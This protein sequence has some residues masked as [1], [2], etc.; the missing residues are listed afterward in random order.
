MK[1]Y[2]LIFLFFLIQISIILF[3][4]TP[5]V[6]ASSNFQKFSQNPIISGRGNGYWEGI[7]IVAPSV[8]KSSNQY[9]MWF[10]GN[11]GSGWRIGYATSNNGINNWSINASPLITVGTPDGWEKEVI[12]P[13]VI[14]D[15]SSNQYKMW[16]TSSNTDHWSVGSDRFRLRYATSNDGITWNIN[17]GWV[18]YGTA[19]AWDEGGI[20]RGISVVKVND[21]YNLWY[22]A[23]NTDD[24]GINPYWRIGYATSSDGIHWDKQNNHLPVIEPTEPWEGNNV[25]SP[26]VIYENGTYK[27]WYNSGVADSPNQIVYAYSA[28]GIHWIKPFDKNPSLSP[29]LGFD[30]V[31]VGTPSVL[32]DNG[33]YKMWYSG[34]D[35]QN[36]EIGYAT[37]LNNSLLPVPLLKQTNPAWAGQVYDGAD[38]WDVSHKTIGDWGCAMTSAAMIL[39]YHG[40]KK[41]P[42]GT[43]LDPGTLNTWLKSQSDGY[44]DGVTSGYMNPL[45]ITRLAKNAVQINNITAFDALEYQHISGAN[46]TQ[47]TDDLNNSQPDMLEEP[48]HFIVAKGID[49]N[50][51]D[52]N[53]PYY[54]RNDLTNGYNNTFLSLNRYIPSH[55]DLSYIMITVNPNVTITVKDGQGHIVGGQFIQQPYADPLNHNATKNNPLK[56]VLI[57]KPANGNYQLTIS[58]TTT[59]TYQLHTYLYDLQGNVHSDTNHGTI[60]TLPDQLN[61]SFNNQH[62]NNAVVNRIVT[63]Q[64][65]IDDVTENVHLQ[66]INKTIGNALI[67]LIKS[68]KESEDKNQKLAAKIKLDAL[69][70]TIKLL[71]GKGI[72]ENA[73]QIL[74]YDETYLKNH[75]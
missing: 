58:S 27:M 13:M 8:I 49:G 51:F 29:S 4:V 21:M 17:P 64:S 5:S 54:D 30:S 20:N 74:L 39:Q 62:I 19:G 10:T 34:Y 52:I 75:I 44:I 68:R 50:T 31:W 61:I 60:S 55:T 40:I 26:N 36:V 24:L 6:N 67:S 7:S 71:R 3:I 2:S 73:F 63:F 12:D 43:L 33:R 38:N 70:I 48:G 37:E 57:P 53:D 25:N 9:Q 65:F 59:Q 56:F 35:N 41:L 66:Q 69:E 45:A 23:T 42:D 11:N 15:D 16:Y 18:L 46:I 22:S 14:Y 72:S 32:N 1:N 28:D 47:L